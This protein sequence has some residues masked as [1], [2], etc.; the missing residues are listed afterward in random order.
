MEQI[1]GKNREGRGGGGSTGPG[2]VALM[3]EEDQVDG[4]KGRRGGGV[5]PRQ[6]QA[7]VQR[8]P[9]ST[10]DSREVSAQEIQREFRVTRD[11]CLLFAGSLD[12]R[13]TE[14]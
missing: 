3:E 1:I 11:S 4:W 2:G 6:F 13:S 12:R 10:A 9:W 8:S 5:A 7:R 14:S